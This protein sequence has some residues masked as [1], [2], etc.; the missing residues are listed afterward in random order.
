MIRAINL[1]LGVVA[2]PCA[3]C[4]SFSG[5]LIPATSPSSTPVPEAPKP[6]QPAPNLDRV[7][8][9][10]AGVA[11]DRFAGTDDERRAASAAWI[12]RSRALGAAVKIEDLHYA[13]ATA[14]D[15]RAGVAVVGHVVNQG[16]ATLSLLAI[17]LAL[18]GPSGVIGNVPLITKPERL[19]PGASK[20][21]GF[22]IDAAAGAGF[23]PLRGPPSER[24]PISPDEQRALGRITAYVTYAGE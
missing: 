14:A 19:A 12:E 3:T 10:P 8:C 6:D 2:L 16:S 4:A 9:H 1:A 20:T 17:H 13:R 24:P 15:G 23:A 11:P 5:G 22:M 7:E 18:T 21:F